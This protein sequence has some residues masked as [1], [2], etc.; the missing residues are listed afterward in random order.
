MPT[1]FKKDGLG[2]VVH[3]REQGH[4]CPH[5]HV[6]GGGQEVIMLFDG[7]ILRGRFAN[8]TLKKRAQRLV[9]EN[10]ALLEAMWRRE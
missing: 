1:A 10:R 4:N 9:R 7:T 5:V 3:Y 8:A 2:F 6:T